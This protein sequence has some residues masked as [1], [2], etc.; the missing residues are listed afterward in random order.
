[1]EK[2]NKLPNSRVVEL[3]S[4]PRSKTKQ[5]SY[6]LLIL[7]KY[8]Y[9]TSVTYVGIN[10]LIRFDNSSSNL[11]SIVDNIINA[12]LRCRNFNIGKNLI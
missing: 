12:E 9:D 4:S 11:V 10:N 3:K 8:E 5:L 2:I 6:A 7:E 1:M